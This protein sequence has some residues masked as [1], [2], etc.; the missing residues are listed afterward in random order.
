MT[1]ARTLKLYKLPDVPQTPGLRQMEGRDVPQVRQ[2]G[3]GV[4]GSWRLA[5]GAGCRGCGTWGL[6][7]R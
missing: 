7:I 5:L 3:G 1:M 2:G 6:R 4:A